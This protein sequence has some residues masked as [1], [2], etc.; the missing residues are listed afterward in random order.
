MTILQENLKNKL[1]KINLADVKYILN[2]LNEKNKYY[3]DQIKT[4]KLTLDK[5]VSINDNL[6]IKQLKRNERMYESLLDYNN[7]LINKLR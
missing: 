2:I 6:T 4:S 7:H 5:Q 3:E 1:N